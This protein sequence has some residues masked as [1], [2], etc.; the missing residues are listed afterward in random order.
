[1]EI[2]DYESSVTLSAGL[3]MLENLRILILD[4]HYVFGIADSLGQ[5]GYLDCLPSLKKLEMLRAPLPFFVKATRDAAGQYCHTLRHPK[6]VLPS[7][8]KHL[9]IEAD[10]SCAVRDPRERTI[11]DFSGIVTEYALTFL[12]ALVISGRQAFPHLRHVTFIDGI[13]LLR[14]S[15]KSRGI[16]GRD[17][18]PEHCFAGYSGPDEMRRRNFSDLLLSRVEVLETMYTGMGVYFE[19]VS[20]ILGHDHREK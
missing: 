14:C 15:C 18:C 2:G 6:N 4:L 1:M 7:S 11:R 20:E 8:L 5:D 19:V 12:E 9:I 3:T 17:N 13:E 10:L 16:G